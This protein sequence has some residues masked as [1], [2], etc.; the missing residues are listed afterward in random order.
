M[1]KGNWMVRS[2]QMN[3]NKELLQGCQ[4]LEGW[5][6]YRDTVYLD[7]EDIE[8]IGIGRNLE[9]Y[10]LE[11]GELEAD[12]TYSHLNAVA[13]AY[14]KLSECRQSVI[15]HNPWVVVAPP[16]VRIILTDMAYNMGIR[17]LNKFK[18]MLLA[19]KLKDYTQGALELQ[20]SKY[21][22]QTGQR[23]LG[24]YRTLCKLGEPK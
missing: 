7:S 13:W 18:R 3:K 23:A 17:G 5:E 2:L 10:P 20:D 9:V 19:L 21:F 6:G 12:G 4:E 11:P 1:K 22:R 8:T 24:H 15:T 14:D 16:E